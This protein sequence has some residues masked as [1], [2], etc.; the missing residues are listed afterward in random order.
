LGTRVTVVYNTPETNRYGPHGEAVAVLGILEC[1]Q[2]VE[3]ALLELQYDVDLLPLSP[4]ASEIKDKL[5]TLQT[6][7]IFNLFEGFEE[8]PETEA[9]VPEAAE[10]L[11]IPYTGCPA[12]TLRLAL[13]KGT[14]K[15]ML[16]AAGIR[17]ADFQVLNP[18]NLREF[19]MRYPCIVKPR[20][21]DASHGMSEHSVVFD[22]NA[23]ERQVELMCTTYGGDALV[24][25][26]IDG[27][28]FN[29]TGMGNSDPVVLPASEIQ[30]HLPEGLP[31]LLTF[32]AKW[33]ED[34]TYFKGTT[35]VCPAPI[36]NAQRR[37]IIQTVTKTYRLFGCRGYARVDLR[38]DAN[39]YFNVIE[40]NPNPDIT[41]GNGTAR[42]AGA[43]G[44]TYTDF[45]CR[46]VQLAFEQKDA[47]YP[48]NA[49]QRQTAR[50]DDSAQYA[51]IPTS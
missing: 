19:H 34:S 40:L 27:R 21:E 11:G 4:P 31:R 25:E 47:Y 9:L 29:A 39:G 3:Q 16:K 48:V 7:L 22:F 10:E 1:V 18:S 30:Y 37:Q 8:S 49:K 12:T 28:E 50:D 51:R 24:E 45:I 44:W 36:T 20:S 35:P 2:A 14:A 42:H 38:M 46:V 41:P 33:E 43:T 32:S 26:F 23:L 5:R 15:A 17:T 13:D 6:S